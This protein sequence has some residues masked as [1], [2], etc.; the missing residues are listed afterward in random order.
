MYKN[1]KFIPIEDL[2]N[3]P[4]KPSSIIRYPIINPIDATL[5]DDYID[6]RIGNTTDLLN[7]AS[8]LKVEDIQG[9]GI[10]YSIEEFNTFQDNLMARYLIDLMYYQTIMI[11]KLFSEN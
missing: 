7:Q 10:N 1:V 5:P 6:Y 2:F 4:I 3:A 8:D 11:N 9:I